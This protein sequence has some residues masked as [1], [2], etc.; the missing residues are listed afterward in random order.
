MT[1]YAFYFST[2][3]GNASRRRRPPALPDDMCAQGQPADA[4]RRRMNTELH[5]RHEDDARIYTRHACS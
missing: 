3:A 1:R 2:S 5:S 4:M